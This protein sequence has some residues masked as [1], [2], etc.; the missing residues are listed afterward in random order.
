M[1]DRDAIKLVLANLQSLLRDCGRIREATMIGDWLTSIERSTDEADLTAL[2]T[3][4]HESM[5]GMGSL[6]DIV[7]TPLPDSSW[8]KIEANAKLADL[9]NELFQLTGR[10]RKDTSR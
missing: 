10:D 7:L 5:V 4:I 2:S 9:S 3:H 6:N 1:I 8:S